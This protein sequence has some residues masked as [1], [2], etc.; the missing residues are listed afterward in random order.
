MFAITPL[1]R[2]LLL[3]GDAGGVDVGMVYL[4]LRFASLAPPLPK[5]EGQELLSLSRV[6]YPR[7]LLAL[8]QR[9]VGTEVRALSVNPTLALTVKS[10]I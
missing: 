8:T 5:R 3:R 9:R 10:R 6:C 2:I 7:F 4:P 1:Y